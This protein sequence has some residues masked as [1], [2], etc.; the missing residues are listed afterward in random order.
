M[1]LTL[2]NTKGSALTHNEMDAN[3]LSFPRLIAAYGARLTNTGNTTE[4]TLATISIPANAMGPNGF[5][6]VTM[7]WTTDGNTNTKTMRVRFNNTVFWAITNSSATHLTGQA[8]G[9]IRNR[10]A[11][12]SQVGMALNVSGFTTG[13]NAA[14]IT[15]AHDTT[16]A[17]DLTI[18]AQCTTSGSDS[19]HLE[20]YSVE[21]CYAS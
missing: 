17:L 6:R 2:R 9:I 11:T 7:L 5:I 15:S 10:N 4:N 13:F 21:V 19:I 18:T 16:G 3:F 12:N 1:A 8:L 14:V 20:G